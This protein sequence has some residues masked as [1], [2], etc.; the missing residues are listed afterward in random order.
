MVADEKYTV[1]KPAMGRVS[2]GGHSTQVVGG[3]G[4]WRWGSCTIVD[5]ATTSVV[6]GA[7]ESAIGTNC[8]RKTGA[9]PPSRPQTLSAAQTIK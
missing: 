7:A 5:D 1:A 2:R 9:Q 4:G 8:R 6:V 3:G